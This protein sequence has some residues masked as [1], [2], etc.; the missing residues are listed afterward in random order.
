MKELQPQR[1]HTDGTFALQA[2][3][4]P[5]LAFVAEDDLVEAFEMLTTGD[6]LTSEMDPVVHNFEGTWTGRQSANG[7]RIPPFP[8]GLWNCYNAVSDGKPLIMSSDFF[9]G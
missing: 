7:H 3:L 1:Q 9:M 5:A 8:T 4:L 2:K 6:V